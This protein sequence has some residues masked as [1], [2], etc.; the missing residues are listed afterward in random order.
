MA[1]VSETLTSAVENSP[2]RAAG[3]PDFVLFAVAAL[4]LLFFLEGLALIPYIGLQNDEML[5]A[6]ALFPPVAME[7]AVPIAGHRVP[8]MVMSYVGALKSW[9][10]APVFA[11]WAPSEW[12]VRIPVLLMGA[13][14]IALFFAFA[15]GI[16]GKRAALAAAALLAT[17]AMFVVTTGLDWGPVALQHF[18][19]VAGLLLV[20]EFDRTA[21]RIWLAAGFFA[22]GL[23]LWDKALFSWSLAGLG[24]ASALVLPRRVAKHI[25]WRNVA[26]A[27]LGFVL[28][29]AP[30][31]AYNAASRFKTFRSNAEFTT[32]GIGQK[33][34]ALRATLEGSAL[35]GYIVR[36]DAP[37][38][39]GKAANAFEGAALA[40][41]E[42]FGEPRSGY[43]GLA[44]VV[45]FALLPWLWR[46]PAR[47]PM[48]FSLIF[49]AAV[50][51][52]MAFTRNAGGSAHHAVLLW[53]FP[54]LFVA[55]ALSQVSSGFRRIGK[56]VL[57]LAIAF[58][59]AANVLVL[60]RYVARAIEDGTSVI[61]TDAISPLKTALRE[62][63]AGRIYVADWGMMNVLRA[64]GEGSLPLEIGNDPFMHTPMTG[65]DREF[66]T[67]MLS[68]KDAI[69]IGHTE[70]NEILSG[71]SARLLEFAQA[72]GHRKQVLRVI[73]DR[74]GRPIF[75]IY[76]FRAER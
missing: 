2:R 38:E 68:R 56:P 11:V 10:Y 71:V 4:C 5:F 64:T 52:Q 34:G 31:L 20:C 55:A 3:L 63:P 53:P 37:V 25:T 69:W 66:A 62:M 74:D 44:L 28:G 18:L 1:R 12:S 43:M 75:E 9:M 51:V 72:S 35:F 36:E 23:A 19:L 40:L 15:M 13:I 70:G 48:V 39:P 58:L 33:V 46:T 14:T 76:R 59:C 30:L 49:M 50:W 8:T 21:R 73:S 47:K 26:A 45:A 42:F 22:F 54:Q 67:R 6:E 17:D 16:C 32:E 7:H 29:A 61:W 65:L 57:A 41:S 24:A 60:D 27:A